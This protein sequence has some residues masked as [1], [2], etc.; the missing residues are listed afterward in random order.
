MGER[1]VFRT[2]CAADLSAR[3]RGRTPY[4]GISPPPKPKKGEAYASVPHRALIRLS[5]RIPRALV[6]LGIPCRA[7]PLVRMPRLCL[8]RAHARRGLGRRGR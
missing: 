6:E 5:A 3:R 4:A 2:S 8:T 7:E 1:G